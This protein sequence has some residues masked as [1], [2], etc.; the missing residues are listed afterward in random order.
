VTALGLALVLTAAGC[1][2]GRDALTI[3]SGRGESLVGPLLQRFNEETGIPIDVRYGDSSQLALQIDTEGERSPADVF[4]SQ[5]P[6][7]TGFLADE[8]LLAPIPPEDLEQ[9]DAV[10]ESAEGLWV[11]LTA[12]QRVLVY[13]TDLLDEADL[14]TSVLDVNEAPYAGEVAVAPE[15]GSFQDFVTAL[16]LL[17]GAEVQTSFLEGLAEVGAPT[18]ANN[19]A[20]VEAVGRGEVAMG[21]VNHYYALRFLAEDPELPVANHRFADGD[22]GDVILPS[23]ASILASSDDPRAAELV[24]F[25][26]SEGAQRFFA[27]ETKEY[28]LVAGVEPAVDVPPLD[29]GSAPSIDVDALGD[30]L[31]ETVEKISEAGL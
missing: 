28:P 31:R 13:N 8:D 1:G 4:Y 25:L 20:I 7:A 10:Y 9:V 11:G 27:D 16:G 23:T 29:V 14:P 12:R 6:G 24:A 22:P 2:G 17:E 3:Y 30:G 21:L 5:S 19:N 18:Y 26:L 15:N